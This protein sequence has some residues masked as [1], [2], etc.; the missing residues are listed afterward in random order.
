MSPQE[1]ESER[2]TVSLTD[3][4]W[5]YHIGSVDQHPKIKKLSQNSLDEAI[6]DLSFSP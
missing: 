5:S 4:M 2:E 1:M 3:Y 6:K